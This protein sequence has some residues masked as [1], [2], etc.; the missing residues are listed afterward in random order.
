MKELLFLFTFLATITIILSSCNKT[1]KSVTE[2]GFVD[3]YPAETSDND[4]ISEAE[5]PD[6]DAPEPEFTDE[7]FSSDP[8]N[9]KLNLFFKSK[10]HGI[11]EWNNEYSYF[12]NCGQKTNEQIKVAVSDK[13]T[14]DGKLEKN[15]YRFTPI[16]DKLPDASCNISITCSDD[17]TEVTQTT[18]IIIPNP[19]KFTTLPDLEKIKISNTVWSNSTKTLFIMGS[20]LY[21][22]DND[23]K[24]IVIL[25]QG[26]I[27]GFSTESVYYYAT[28]KGIFSTQGSLS[29]KKTVF[30]T[31]SIKISFPDFTVIKNLGF[32]DADNNLFFNSDKYETMFYDAEEKK[33]FRISEELFTAYGLPGKEIFYNSGKIFSFNSSE[34][35]FTE[36]CPDATI[37]T[38]DTP[39]AYFGGRFFYVTY[40]CRGG[41][42]TLHSLDTKTCA[43]EEIGWCDKKSYRNSNFLFVACDGY[44]VGIT[45]FSSDGSTKTL[46]KG[47]Y[48]EDVE[49]KDGNIVFVANP[50]SQKE[51]IYECVSVLNFETESISSSD[52]KCSKGDIVRFAGFSEDKALYSIYGSKLDG[53]LYSVDHSGK[54]E[55]ITIE[56][57][58]EPAYLKYS[59]ISANSGKDLMI[60]QSQNESQCFLIGGNPQNS[61]LL[62]NV[63]G[64]VLTLYSDRLLISYSDG[65]Y[66][67]LNYLAA[68]NTKTGKKTDIAN[69]Y[70]ALT[71]PSTYFEGIYNYKVSTGGTSFFGVGKYSGIYNL[72][73]SNGSE[74]CSTDHEIEVSHIYTNR[75]R[76]TF[77]IIPDLFKRINMDPFSGIYY[78]VTHYIEGICKKAVETGFQGINLGIIGEKLIGYAQ[79]TDS[80]I[81][82]IFSLKKG[83]FDQF[84]PFGKL[85]SS[86]SILNNAVLAV[87]IAS[88]S[89]EGGNL[90]VFKDGN[91][92]ADP[93]S[94]PLFSSGSFSNIRKIISD[95]KNYTVYS[96]TDIDTEKEVYKSVYYDGNQITENT[97]N[98]SGVIDSSSALTVFNGY[99]FFLENDNL[100]AIPLKKSSE[101][102]ATIFENTGY[103][104]KYLGNSYFNKAVFSYVPN[105]DE[106]E[107]GYLL[108]VTDGIKI[109]LFE[110]S[111]SSL[112]TN[113]P[114]IM[115]DGWIKTS[116]SLINENEEGKLEEIPIGEMKELE[117]N[118]IKTENNAYYYKDSAIYIYHLPDPF[119]E[120]NP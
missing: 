48:V 83:A 95:N 33:V 44:E 5:N 104:F 51:E 6:A 81:F 42:G 88:E 98:Y 13:D 118:G 92:A 43:T 29:N 85:Y 90:L 87:E 70:S 74:L 16:K 61:K 66:R 19:F 93:L 72:W 1:G 86:V 73:S 57:T 26:V 75:Y 45:R 40:D 119:Y 107:K 89:S 94:T 23:F 2:I 8:N 112:L 10:P 34:R 22:A 60:L 7:D 103:Y 114:F 78:G 47:Y 106:T 56:K 52:I 54:S 64:N 37:P 15:T 27:S 30:T 117:M 58:V 109:E 55:R 21:S 3:D 31:D 111:K 11:I 63:F 25:D 32:V 99:L 101:K 18:Q 49:S 116:Y 82:Q 28:E 17:V 59:A 50:P 79:S 113:T 67:G 96:A 108:I 120:S 4:S 80:T 65:K 77:R 46:G 41:N 91:L 69:A 84:T 62:G 35:I 76:E 14:C 36:L 71:Y 20:D 12:V 97:L 53:D 105:Y 68:F 102:A 9:E 110:Q 24:N 39:H 38:I 100:K 115:W